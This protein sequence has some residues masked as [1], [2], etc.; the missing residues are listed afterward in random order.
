MKLIKSYLIQTIGIGMSIFML[1]FFVFSF[2]FMESDKYEIM[3]ASFSLGILFYIISSSRIEY[4]EHQIYIKMFIWK[5]K[6]TISQIKSI[7]YS[8]LPNV[9][10]LECTSGNIYMPLFY[11]KQKMRELFEVIKKSNPSIRC[12]KQIV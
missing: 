3:V 1:S 10:M 8:G 9:C 12:V 2:L 11:P 7:T 5:K 4:D 6:I